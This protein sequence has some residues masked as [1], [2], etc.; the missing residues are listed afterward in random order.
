MGVHLVAVAWHADTLLAYWDW[1][2]TILEV[3]IALGLVIFV[4]ELGHFAVAKLCGVKC[5]KFYLGFDIAG[6][7]FWRHRWGETEY[8]IGILPLGGYVK[9]LGQEDNP[10]RLKEEIDRAKA[11]A[12]NGAVDA[13]DNIKAEQ[14]LYDPRS[15]LAQSVPKRMAIISAG[16]LMNLIFA[17]VVAVVAY[18]IG[19]RQLAAGVG[20]IVPGLAAWQSNLQ[21]GDTILK[22]AGHKVRRF[23]DVLEAVSLGDVKDGFPIVVERPG[24]KKPFSITVTPEST[25]LLPRIGIT[26]PLSTRLVKNGFVALPGSAAAQAEPPFE[27]GDRIVEIEGRPIDNY[28][29]INACFARHPD[30]TLRVR[31]E[32]FGK[33]SGGGKALVPT[34]IT[35]QLPPDPMHDLGLVMEMGPIS[36]VQEDSPAAAAGLQPGDVIRAI[37]GQPAGD[38]LTLPYRL[39]SRVGQTVTLT[40]GRQAEKEPRQLQ[41]TLRGVDG[42]TT[43]LAEDSPVAVPELGVCYHVLNRVAAA[44]PGSPAAKAGLAAGDELTSAAI[45]PPDTEAYRKLKVDQPKIALAF[46]ASHRNWW[47]LMFALQATV[48]GTTVK[49]D[50]RRPGSTTEHQAVLTPEVAKHWFDPRRGLYFEPV[51]VF[52]TAQTW[53]E[54]IAEGGRETLNQALV[55]YRT[56]RKLGSQVSLRALGGPVSIFVAAK[57]AAQKGLTNLLLFLTF[58][59]ANLAVLNFLP[60][61]LLDGGL[62]VFLLWE[63]VRG[64][65]ANERVQVVLTY[66]GL[67]FIIVL[68]LWVCGLDFGLIPRR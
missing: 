47:S 37:D 51:Y 22:I 35:I 31:V 16:V 45:L 3:A 67:A 17:F 12:A 27:H 32:R 29:Q 44:Q 9:M 64:K 63:A 60:I 19:V 48:P 68:T 11:N 33:L 54:A 56:L 61:P 28:G 25:G 40:V 53:P 21:V 55:V 13:T 43:P 2:L 66:L 7:R 1:T 57:M 58:L 39:R 52:L 46:N 26:N 50:W 4:H 15:F 8:G 24:A 5:E 65:P 18:R 10:A 36:A 23:Q 34:P 30:R 42:Y 49:L 14:A 20:E 41:V 59:S 62:M 38:P 6:L